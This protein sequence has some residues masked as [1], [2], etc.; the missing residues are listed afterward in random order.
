LTIRFCR[1]GAGDVPLRRQDEECSS[2]FAARLWSRLMK[3]NRQ[4]S[5]DP[6]IDRLMD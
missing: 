6:W 1:G 3:R 5:W 2:L 4:E